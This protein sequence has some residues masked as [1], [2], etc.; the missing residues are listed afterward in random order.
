[1]Q[2]EAV[3]HEHACGGGCVYRF[4]AGT[5]G[6]CNWPLLHLGASGTL[7]FFGCFATFATFALC[8]FTTGQGGMGS[9]SPHP[10]PEK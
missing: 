10:V 9:S 5:L 2:L 4:L 6:F 3:P 8:Y 7:L 1:M